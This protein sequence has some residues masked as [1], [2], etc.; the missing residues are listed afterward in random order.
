MKSLYAV[1]TLED[2]GGRRSGLD[3]R[4][5]LERR[6]RKED[7]TNLMVSVKPKRKTDV[8]IEA[9]R[10]RLWLW[11]KRPCLV[12]GRIALLQSIIINMLKGQYRL[13][14]NGKEA[15]GLYFKKHWK[16][17]ENPGEEVPLKLNRPSLTQEIC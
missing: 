17:V 3:R 4:S 13:L 6:I 15:V 8:Y 7:F 16:M 9:L 2:Q 5:G 1:V 11:D 14:R 10:L 12:I